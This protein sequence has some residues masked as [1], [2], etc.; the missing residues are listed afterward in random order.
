[1]SIH[2]YEVHPTSF[3]LLSELQKLKITSFQA[4]IVQY[5]DAH[6]DLLLELDGFLN[7]CCGQNWPLLPNPGDS[8]GGKEARIGYSALKTNAHILLSTYF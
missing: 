8:E 3:L 5:R 2:T 4:K 6:L 7:L 1:M